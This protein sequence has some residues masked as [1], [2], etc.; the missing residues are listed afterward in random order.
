VVW[1]GGIAESIRSF[2][3][4]AL[5]SAVPSTSTSTS[6]CPYS[7]TPSAKPFADASPATP[8]PSDA[9]QRPFLS[10]DATITTTNN[11]ELV[12][13]LNGRTYSPI[14]RQA[15]LPASTPVPWWGNRKL[16]FEYE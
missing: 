15:D 8:P 1:A 10:A 16:R 5:S 14:L 7:P 4:D 11:T 13:R 12:V 6:G 2:H 3:L 9:L